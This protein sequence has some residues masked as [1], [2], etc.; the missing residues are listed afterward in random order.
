MNMKY[1]LGAIALATVATPA[2]A[3]NEFYIVQDSATKICSV[4]EQKPTAVDVAQVG[5]TIYKTQSEA[6]AAMK[7]APLCIAR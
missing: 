1:A 2:L 6:D 4:V 7:V 5:T 3:A